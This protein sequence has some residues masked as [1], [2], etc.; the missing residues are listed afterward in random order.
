MFAGT[1]GWGS[2]HK[3]ARYHFKQKFQMRRDKATAA[4]LQ[5][6]MSVAKINSSIVL[7]NQ[8][9]PAYLQVPRCHRV[10]GMRMESSTSY[11]NCQGKLVNGLVA[12]L[13]PFVE[14]FVQLL[15]AVKCQQSIQ[16]DPN[17]TLSH[18]CY[19]NTLYRS[20][21]RS[22]QRYKELAYTFGRFT[23]GITTV[24]S[25]DGASFRGALGSPPGWYWY[26]PRPPPSF[27]GSLLGALATGASEEE[28]VGERAVVLGSAAFLNQ[29]AFVNMPIR[30]PR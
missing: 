8:G 2:S 23:F 11:N 13:A 27:Q 21:V 28:E 20:I 12:V 18:L 16:I 24:L 5:K 3:V 26:F 7:H 10:K 15:Q 9:N 14:F 6:N 22:I 29:Q 1:D 25:A 4:V 19:P 30:R 17:M